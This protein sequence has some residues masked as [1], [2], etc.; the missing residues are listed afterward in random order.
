MSGVGGRA[1]SCFAV[2]HFALFVRGVGGG[3]PPSPQQV[4]VDGRQL[5]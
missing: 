4:V 3:A 5:G 2:L 1:E